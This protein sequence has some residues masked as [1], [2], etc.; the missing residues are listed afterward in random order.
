MCIQSFD[1]THKSIHNSLVPVVFVYYTEIKENKG[2]SG[3]PNINR[4]KY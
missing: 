1:L 3:K 4:Y 2:I